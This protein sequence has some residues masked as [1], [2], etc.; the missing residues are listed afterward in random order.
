MDINPFISLDNL[1]LFQKR[2]K[3]VSS[4]SQKV[5]DEL[6]RLASLDDILL[7]QK[8]SKSV[9]SASQKVRK[10]PHEASQSHG[11]LGAGPQNLLRLGLFL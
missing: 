11:G 4:A 1:L 10:Q 9:C 8:R 7:F 6:H 2:S 3:S 5:V